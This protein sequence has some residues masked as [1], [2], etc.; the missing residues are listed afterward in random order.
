MAVY[1]IINSRGSTVAS[2]NVATTTG[3]TFP[4]ELI[5]QGISLY[6]PQAN[7]NWFH[8]LEHFANNVEPTNPV[9]GMIWHNTDTTIPEYYDGVQFVPFV[10]AGSGAGSLFNMLPSATGIDF[11]SGGTTA[12]FT[13]PGTAAT[14]HP[15]GILLIP[16]TVNAVTTPAIFNLQ[17]T[18]SEDV[19]ENS[20]IVNPATTRHAFFNIQ[21]TTAFASNV[22]SI[23]L[24]VTTP[25]TGGAGLALT[26]DA[27][28]F[29]FTKF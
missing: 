10:T 3:T 11:T 26:M 14:F 20:S 15:T 25:A 17:V 19:L 24:E 2:I 4:V 6:G 5:G 18:V 23:S 28:L 21:G 13:A 12:I 22:D 16:T 9:E 1:T 27:Y 7:T 8:L 29:G